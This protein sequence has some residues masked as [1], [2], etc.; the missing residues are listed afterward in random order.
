MKECPELQFSDYQLL[1][2]I[3][4]IWFKSKGR[5]LVPE[6]AFEVELTT[7]IWGGV[8]RMGTLLDYSNVGLYV[9]SNDKKRFKQAIST[10]HQ[11]REEIL[12]YND[13]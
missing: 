3:D 11:N 4:V 13:H 1:R 2:Q 5:N 8:V 7:G 10:F 9:I 6:K 12:C